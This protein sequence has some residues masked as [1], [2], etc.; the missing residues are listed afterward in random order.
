VS[1]ILIRIDSGR[2]WLSVAKPGS[3]R[4]ES[5][6]AGLIDKRSSEVAGGQSIP[7]VSPPIN[8]RGHFE[9][10]GRPGNLGFFSDRQTPTYRRTA[11]FEPERSAVFRPCG[12]VSSALTT[13]DY[14][15]REPSVKTLT[16]L[17]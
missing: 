4:S 7:R 13:N 2:A 8:Q 1:P 10:E 16:L 9:T 17:S 6:R 3:L 15:W 5:A 14:R 11:G 12:V